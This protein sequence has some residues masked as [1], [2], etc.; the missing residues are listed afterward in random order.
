MPQIDN[1]E[2]R[3]IRKK[4][5]CFPLWA[6]RIKDRARHLV[7][8]FFPSGQYPLTDKVN[9]LSCQPVFIISA[10]RSGTTLL[11]SMLVAGGNIAIPPETQVIHTAIRRFTALQF[12][13]WADLSRLIVSLFESHPLFYLWDVNLYSVYSSILNL[14]QDERSLARLIDEVFKCYA[15]Q[16]FP[17]AL[18]WGDQSPINTLYLP[19]LIRVFPEAKYL[20][21]LRDGRDAISSMIG[22]GRPSLEQATMRWIVSVE[23]ALALQKQLTSEQFLEIRYEALVR[24]PSETVKRICEFI[25][26]EYS[27]RML[28]F[29]KL[30]STVEHHHFEYHQNLKKPVFSN[31]IG[32]WSQRL[33]QDEQQ[34][35]TSKTSNLLHRLGYIETS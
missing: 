21:L 27:A 10:G 25:D 31:S 20:H 2:L 35:V 12:M 4:Y 23:R 1:R 29:W 17:E 5:R 18:I 34:Y 19:W 13:G 7:N 14:P 15:T 8:G 30:P 11:R 24:E 33:S 9:S 28:E 32:K 26:I 3:L 16:Q 22:T 6:T